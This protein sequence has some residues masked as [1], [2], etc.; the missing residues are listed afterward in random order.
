MMDRASA[1]VAM[2]KAVHEHI[3]ALVKV[4]ISPSG[5]MKHFAKGMQRLKS[6][7]QKMSDALDEV[8]GKRLSQEKP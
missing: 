7:E 1:Y 4:A 6:L 8:F 5:D 2:Q 3:E